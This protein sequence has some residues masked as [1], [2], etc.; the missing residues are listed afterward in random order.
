[1]R[2]SLCG[3]GLFVQQIPGQ[4]LTEAS[5]NTLESFFLDFFFPAKDKI[6]ICYLIDPD[7]EVN[8]DDLFTGSTDLRVFVMLHLIHLDTTQPPLCSG[9]VAKS[10]LPT[11]LACVNCDRHFPITA[12]QIHRNSCN[13]GISELTGELAYSPAEKMFLPCYPYQ[14]Q[15][16]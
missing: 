7:E 5:S 16:I 8:M 3:L 10:E 1:M 14:T 12:L 6:L 2:W 11:L 15:S 9:W 4:P 13:R